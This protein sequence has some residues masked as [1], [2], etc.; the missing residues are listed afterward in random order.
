M[1]E[2]VDR[3]CVAF[4]F[5]FLFSRYWEIFRQ[6]FGESC[7]EYQILQFLKIF[8]RFHFFQ[9]QISFSFHFFLF[10]EFLDSSA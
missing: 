2:F 8:K 10:H 7:L 9:I 3:L 4:N 5:H 6:I 1:M